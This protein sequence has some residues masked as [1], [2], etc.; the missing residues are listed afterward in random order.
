MTENDKMMMAGM[1]AGRV[2][3]DKKKRLEAAKRLMPNV[4][5][6][7]DALDARRVVVGRETR[8]GGEGD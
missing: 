2:K 8:L 5:T 7:A 4:Y 3:S 6:A 1:I